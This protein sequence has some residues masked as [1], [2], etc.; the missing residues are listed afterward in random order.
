[1]R[2]VA[3][4][5]PCADH[6]LNAVAPLWERDYEGCLAS[7]AFDVALY[8]Y[9]EHEEGPYN[10]LRSRFYVNPPAPIKSEWCILMGYE[11]RKSEHRC[12]LTAEDRKHALKHFGYRAIFYE[13]PYL[14]ESYE[15][16]YSFVSKSNA[17]WTETRCSAICF[18]G[19]LLCAYPCGASGDGSVVAQSDIDKDR[20][21]LSGDFVIAEYV[22]LSDGTWE[23]L[24]PLSN[25]RTETL[26]L[27]VDPADFYEKLRK[28]ID[29][30]QNLPEWAWC[31]A[32]NIVDENG[33]GSKKK[34]VHGTRYFAPGTKV[35]LLGDVGGNGWE[36][37]VVAGI[38]K[39]LDR[40]VAMYLSESKI[41]NFHVE[42]VSSRPVLSAMASNA[43][44]D[45]YYG[46]ANPA[47]TGWDDSLDSEN[48][49]ALLAQSWCD[50]RNEGPLDRSILDDEEWEQTKFLHFCE[51]CGRQE[52]ITG[53]EAQ[54]EGWVYPSKIGDFAIVSPRLCGDCARIP[55]VEKMTLAH[56]ADDDEWGRRDRRKG[57]LRA[58][59]NAEAKVFLDENLEEHCWDFRELVDK[60][61]NF[62]KSRFNQ[63]M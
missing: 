10:F 8:D 11:P 58:Y 3:I 36:R 9:S 14:Y 19:R 60:T 28:A 46:L 27:N 49:A 39:K 38:P 23:L 33:Y 4:L 43:L 2:R 34:T 47:Y 59:I 55:G 7:G 63:A 35:Y 61:K 15:V 48:L 50:E 51:I 22:K 13:S 40:Y 56:G 45:F 16:A 37:P 26:P 53:P 5:F 20:E 29:E 31:V 62:Y 44:S 6:D 54:E 52:Y 32:G 41:E 21:R 17:A 42:K 24:E 30:G 25:A 57:L 12:W 18:D 1:M